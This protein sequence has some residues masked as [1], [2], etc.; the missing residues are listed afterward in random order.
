MI[1][2]PIHIENDYFWMKGNKIREG[3]QIQ[4]YFLNWVA[5]VCVFVILS[6]KLFVFIKY[7]MIIKSIQYQIYYFKED[8]RVTF[9]G[10]GSGWLLEHTASIKN[11]DFYS[12]KWFMWG[13]QRLCMVN[14][15]FKNLLFFLKRNTKPSYS[16][17]LCWKTS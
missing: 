10:K 2:V 15:I 8:I 9:Q 17:P 5:S 11:W 6:Y 16:E 3:V 14:I 1:K 13:A 4:L 12:P 7:F